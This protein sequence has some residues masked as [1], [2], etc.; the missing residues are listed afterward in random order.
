M[1]GYFVDDALNAVI[2]MVARQK[3][4]EEREKFVGEL[5]D[6]PNQ[7]DL[8]FWDPRRYDTP[9]DAQ[10]NLVSLDPQYKDL[11]LK[12]LQAL[13]D[14]ADGS[15]TAQEDAGRMQA[16]K[17]ANDLAKSREEGVLNDARSRGVGGGGLEFA[18]RN[19][20][21]QESANRLGELTTK[22]AAD[23]ALQRL[24]A[25]GQY[26]QGVSN[27]RTQEQQMASQN[28]DILNQFNMYNTNL[29]NSTNTANRNM[30]NQ[31]ALDKVNRTETRGQRGFN[32]ALSGW[33]RKAGF[34]QQ[35]INDIYD[36]GKSLQA[37]NEGFWNVVRQAAAS[38]AG[39]GAGGAMG[40]GGGGA[41]G[42]NIGQ[43]MGGAGGGAGGG[44]AAGGT[45]YSNVSMP[46]NLNMSSQMPNYSDN[47]WLFQRR[48]I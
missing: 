45:G 42:F 46:M 2:G 34:K 9:E 18:L 26:S 19:Q 32:N 22:G 30:Q 27:M 1:A 35:D 21:G 24:A 36:E 11:Q 37:V 44:A 28:A 17:E 10:S 5:P 7:A 8:P 20:A 3:A 48:G 23:A 39:G 43:F 6:G 25:M 12:A 38:G 41:G 16:I 13:R 14:K 47:D 31:A 15:A 40:G 29:H 33:D 4:Q